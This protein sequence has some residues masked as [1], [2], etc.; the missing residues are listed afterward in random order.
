MTNNLTT[1]LMGSLQAIIA[2]VDETAP[3]EDPLF[4]VNWFDTKSAWLYYIYNVFAAASVKAVGGEVVIKG[5]VASVLTGDAQDRRDM[6]L[7]VRYP[8]G[9]RF[10]QMLRSRYFQLV[11]L[12]RVTAV[13]RFTFG[14]TQPTVPK[15]AK[16]DADKALAYSICHFRGAD[17]SVELTELASQHGAVPVYG[18]KLAARLGTQKAGADKVDVPCLMDGTVIL[19]ATNPDAFK[20]ILSDPDFAAVAEKPEGLF[21]ATFERLM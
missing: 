20:D 4:A 2:G 18:G 1:K 11:S 9:S 10:L 16:P 6:L 12:M 13:S 3:L 7:I 5:K 8:S 21:I 14:F 17:V 19:Q 15:T